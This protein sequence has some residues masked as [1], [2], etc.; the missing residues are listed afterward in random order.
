MSF[1]KK[2]PRMKKGLIYNTFIMLFF[3]CAIVFLIAIA[4]LIMVK[5]SIVRKVDTTNLEAE[6]FVQAL[7]DTPEVTSYTDTTIQ[8]QYKGKILLENFRQT[9]RIETLLNERFSSGEFHIIAAELKLT[10][11]QG[12]PFPS[13]QDSLPPIYYAREWYERW[14]VLAGSL[15]PGVGGVDKF[16]R[17]KL[18]AVEDENGNMHNAI[19]EMTVLVPRS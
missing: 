17:K 15:L 9:T 14:Y 19:L 13:P 12:E 8:R 2:K 6:L 11:L 18:V 5:S 10:T 3:R 1:K 16:K 7:M 4:M